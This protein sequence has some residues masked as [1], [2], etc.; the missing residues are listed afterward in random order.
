[1]A[2]QPLH[3][4]PQ[5]DQSAARRM[6]KLKP[7]DPLPEKFLVLYRAH[8]NLKC[9][10]STN[11]MNVDAMACLLLMAGLS[12]EAPSPPTLFELWRDRKIVKGQKVTYEF[13]DAK[14]E[15]AKKE[16]CTGRI[17]GVDPRHKTINV[18]DDATG[19]TRTVPA[20]EVKILEPEPAEPAGV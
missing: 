13:R 6:L 15:K 4:M 20:T 17:A 5:V 18:K 12:V 3:T 11:P 8:R 16:T 9:R 1:M 10:M 2:A 14:D 19:K 7:T